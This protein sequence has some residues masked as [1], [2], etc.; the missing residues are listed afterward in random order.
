MKLS[1]LPALPI[2]DVL[3]QLC[4]A[5]E[6][7]RAVVLSAEPG[8]GKTT[9]APLALV[10]EP[11][12]SGK[13]I[14][15]VEP[16]RIAARMAAERLSQL[17][18]SPLGELIGYHVRF[19]KKSGPRT[20]IEV[21]TEG[22]LIRQ[23]QHDPDLSGVGLVIFDEF[24]ERSLQADLALALCLDVHTLR[25]DLRLMVMSA[26]MA[27]EQV[28][29]LLD[30]AP[31]IS[32]QGHCF[33][34]D[35]HYRP[36]P[37]ADPLL[38]HVGRAIHHALRHHD[39]DILVF[40]PGA[41][42]IHRLEREMAG[43]YGKEIC[44]LPV[45][46][47]MPLARQQRIFAPCDKRRLILATPIAETS[48]TIE[49]VQVVIDS[50]LRKTPRFSAA[51]GLTS[52][53]TV[54][55]AQDSANQR[56]G[57]AG[58][59]G[60][61]CCYRLWSQAEQMG[62]PQFSRPE[63]LAAD[64]APLLLTCLHWGVK[65]P[66][67]LRWLD[68]PRP[69][70]IRAAR[71]LLNRLGAVDR[72]GG[73]NDLGQRLAQLPCHPRLGLMLLR[74]K[75]QGKGELA[76][77]LA[78]L[79][80]NRDPLQGGQGVDIDLRL[81]VLRLCQEK[82][83]A[84]AE[85]KGAD[86]LLCRR[87]LRE[88]KQYRRL[89]NIKGHGQNRE[90]AGC[91][92]AHA[93][94]DR[95]AMKKPGAGHYLLASGKGAVLPEHDPL[96]FTDFLVA[97]N[98]DGGRKQ[99]RIFLAAPLSQTEIELEHGHLLQERQQVIWTGKRVEAAT[100]LTLE[101]LEIPRHPLA[102]VDEEAVMACLAG[103]IRELG[104]QCLHW[105]KKARELQQR[106]LYA[107]EQAPENWPDVSDGALLADLGWLTPYLT[108]VRTRK[109][110]ASLDPAPMLR[111][112]LSWEQQQELDRLL[113]SHLT[114]ASGSRIKLRY[115][116][117]R[118][119]VL[120]VRLQEMFGESRTPTIF[121]GT[122]PVLIQL[123]SPAHRPIQLTRDL[124]GFWQTTYHEVKKELKGR[125]PKHYWPDDPLTAQATHRTKPRKKKIRR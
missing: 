2:Q 40:L 82:R 90:G 76:A 123:L 17:A 116:A 85:S 109:Q 80:E 114:V 38:P 13:K 9:L 5:F 54:T 45:Y 58:R 55:I 21:I 10:D 1:S 36:R 44:C 70:G 26:T 27:C 62:R 14:L 18:G 34:V 32:G 124:A 47:N 88:A 78:A 66:A 39:G 94:P 98:L 30:Q 29:R 81:D 103:A 93:Y 75:E 115:E 102:T 11:W 16:R 31:V 68:P 61:G 41:G 105:S 12:L 92:L 72:E 122:V 117:G 74:G 4:Q 120:A 112:L 57:R 84:E 113:P 51:T 37:A 111:D 121:N 106:L 107:H 99:A 73:L 79:V 101:K 89:L 8:S 56:A 108:G 46:G 35:I 95:I 77:L 23:L 33:A 118:P 125:Y 3:P 52:L 64:L 59:L 20:R 65:D 100:I 22:I 86:T 91:L 49:G 96:Q 110:L 69:V 53:D 67:E 24:H 7:H 42:E 87:I 97:A 50:G 15:L 71:T 48:L 25:H 63:I 119:P 19:E 43:Q 104:I 60:P 28:S 6:R 83:L